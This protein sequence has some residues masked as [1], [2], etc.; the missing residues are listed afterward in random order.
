ML[1]ALCLSV[2]LGCE[3]CT[4]CVKYKPMTWA[5]TLVY[6]PNLGLACIDHCG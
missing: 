2:K 3:K 4:G 6:R 5:Y 1:G